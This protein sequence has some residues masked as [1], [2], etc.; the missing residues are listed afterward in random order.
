[1]PC[2]GLGS[3]VQVRLLVLADRPPPGDVLGW[4][5]GND[6]DVVVCCGDLDLAWIDGLR[7]VAV[8]KLGVYG[9]HDAGYMPELGI[10]DLH[11]ARREVGGVSFAGFEGCVRYRDGPHQYTQ[12]QASALASTLPAADVL[13]C[14][15]PPAGV[16][17]EPGDRAHA[18]F[19]GLREWVCANVPHLVLHG[20]THPRPAGGVRRV[21]ATRVVHVC[22]AR[23]VELS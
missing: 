7:D 15:A 18:G 9:N 22:G 2:F 6:P 14:H 17:D 20:H 21:G 4:V 11:L 23:V 10:A 13:V 16:N 19:D 1:M 12:E 8:P 5:R 3:T